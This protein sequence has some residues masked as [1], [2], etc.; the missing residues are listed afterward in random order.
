MCVLYMFCWNKLFFILFSRQFC[1]FSGQILRLISLDVVYF[2]LLVN[3]HFY[4]ENTTKPHDLLKLD[5][6]F[7]VCVGCACVNKYSCNSSRHL[8][9]EYIYH[10]T[11]PMSNCLKYLRYMAIFVEGLLSNKKKRTYSH[12]YH[13]LFYFIQT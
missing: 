8:T 1:I 10:H 11:P 4:W 2:I 7:F 6:L 9:E 3:V 13:I 5:F 12:L